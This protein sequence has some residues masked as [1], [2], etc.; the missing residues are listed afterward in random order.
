MTLH[1]PKFRRKVKRK[2]GYRKKV[3]EIEGQWRVL[4]LKKC[5]NSAP[6]LG[7]PSLEKN[8]E[9]RKKKEK[10]RKTARGSLKHEKFLILSPPLFLKPRATI[11]NP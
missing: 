11:G 4:Q 5:C 10:K 3:S 7:L 6:A 8:E 2:R 9:R 1:P